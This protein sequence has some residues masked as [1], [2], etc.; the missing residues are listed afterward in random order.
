M[1]LPGEEDGELSETVRGHVGIY[2]DT[3]PDTGA[4]TVCMSHRMMDAEGT[5]FAIWYSLEEF[6]ALLALAQ[7]VLAEVERQANT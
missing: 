7:Q 4:L 5:I 3:H 2:V 6:R 1:S